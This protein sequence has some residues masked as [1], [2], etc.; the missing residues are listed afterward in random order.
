MSIE[1]TSIKY[2]K[3]IPLKTI[4]NK[5]YWDAADNHELSLQNCEACKK[6]IHP[7]GPACPRCG[8]PEIGWVNYGSEI[9]GKIYSFVT[10]YIPMLPGFQH[11]LPT[12]IAQVE[13]DG[14][15]GVRIM[16]NIINAKPEDIEIGKAVKM[17]WI[18]IT[19]ERALPQWEVI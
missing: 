8:S 15:E 13:V 19:E 2:E 10:T 18:D 11:D 4:D 12:I 6:A 7:P 1:K 14:V 3:P 5:P 16:A 9:T 17:T